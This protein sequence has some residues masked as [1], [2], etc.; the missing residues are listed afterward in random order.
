VCV[1]VCVC[2]CV[3]ERERERE[4][5]ATV[6]K[7]CS[8]QAKI[9]AHRSKPTHLST[10]LAGILSNSGWGTSMLTCTGAFAWVARVVVHAWQHAYVWCEVVVGKLIRHNKQ[11]HRG[12]SLA[13]P[14]CHG[15]G[16]GL[17]GLQVRLR[18]SIFRC[19][20]S[21]ATSCK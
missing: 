8:T 13:Q 17:H 12:A 18:P 15:C 4:S 1:C 10:W 5:G 19:G 6:F 20:W 21:R 3:R 9:R 11:M 14:A 2:V 16:W 7:R